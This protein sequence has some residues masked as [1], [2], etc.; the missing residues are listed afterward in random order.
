[1]VTPYEGKTLDDSL[2]YLYFVAILFF[3]LAPLTML[4]IWC[5]S[6]VLRNW[7]VEYRLRDSNKESSSSDRNSN[8]NELLNNAIRQER[9]LGICE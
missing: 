4:C 8:P 1:M 2:F 7:C 3:T 9:I 6:C 5:L